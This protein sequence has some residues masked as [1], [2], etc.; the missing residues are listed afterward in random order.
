MQM[1][2]VPTAGSRTHQGPY[3]CDSCTKISKHLSSLQC[4]F[5]EYLFHI[6]ADV[7]QM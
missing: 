6:F 3:T 7:I 4:V 5:S 1:H 2:A